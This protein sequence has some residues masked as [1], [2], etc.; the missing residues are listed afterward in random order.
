MKSKTILFRCILSLLFSATMTCP[1][2]TGRIIYVDDDGPVSSVEDSNGGKNDGSSWENA[3]IFL[4]DALVDA[5]D[6]EKP[7]EIRVAQGTYKPDQVLI[8]I[9]P[10]K[11]PPDSGP[12]ATFSLI[13]NVTIKGGYAGV[14]E[15]DPNVRN[16]ELYVS[17]L[18]GDLDGD[19]IEVDDP[20]DLQYGVKGIRGRNSHNVVS[21]NYNDANAVLDGFT[22]KGGSN[23][24]SPSL[25]GGMFIYKGNPTIINC[26]FTGNAAYEYGGGICIDHH[27]L[28]ISN[29]IIINC[30]FTKNFADR[31]GGIYNGSFRGGL[32]SPG[33]PTFKSL[34]TGNPTIENCVFSN[35]YSTS[36]GAGMYVTG[37]DIVMSNCTFT[38]NFSES[39]GG[40][41][42]TYRNIELENCTFNGN[43]AEQN[44]AI[45]KSS[46]SI[47]NINNCIIWD[48]QNAISD[49]NSSTLTVSYS[50]IEGGWEGAGN[51][52]ID[53][54]FANPG[55]W[56]DANDLNIIAEPNDP[57]AV[58]INGDYHLKSQGGR[59]DPNS[60][61]W[62]IDDVTSPC[63]DTG[64]P[65]TP[66]GDEPMPN[67]GVVNMGAYG[68][69]AEASKSLSAI[70][71]RF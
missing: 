21:S 6:S 9:V 36:A 58:W 18:S 24:A 39:S 46:S 47:L 69:T 54:L 41:I 65:N 13:N 20:F 62:V 26:I 40:G 68:G 44:N 63:I 2:A 33:N 42:F 12:L 38:G 1:A 23:W 22:I 14:N 11:Y 53:P 7:I 8:P 52:D 59:F 35:N 50:D 28:I 3:Y 57:N 37:G 48:G 5:N 16:I 30:T 15:S 55:Y 45:A 67:G 49:S 29:P 27:S 60:E 64:D 61:S 19:D 10:D 17:I 70:G 66:V 4:Q 31:G 25:G 34:S 51:I 32:L 56:A 43:W 71:I